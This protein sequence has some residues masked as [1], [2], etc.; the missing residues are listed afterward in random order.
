ML[1]LAIIANPEEIGLW[2][3]NMCDTEEYAHQK[4][5]CEYLVGY[6]EAKGIKVTISKNSPICRTARMY[7]FE[8]VGISCELAAKRKAMKTD[9][10][11]REVDYNKAR[12]AY[13]FWR[14]RDY[15]LN[16][17]SNRWR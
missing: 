3:A 11:E 15:E 4:G 17:I 5:A 2:G 7:A 9:L 14:G 8:D 10:A 12:D 6:A 16:D 1:A 13:N